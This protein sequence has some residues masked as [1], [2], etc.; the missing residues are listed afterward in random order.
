MKIVDSSKRAYVGLLILGALLLLGYNAYQS[1][2]VIYRPVLGR[3]DQVKLASRQWDQLE[4]MS[5]L[6]STENSSDIPVDHL[7]SKL[8]SDILKKEPIILQPKGISKAVKKNSNPNE[9]AETDL[10]ILT[11]VLQVSDAQGNVRS[12]AMIDGESRVEGSTVQ[13]FTIDRITKK[14]VTLTRK[15]ESWFLPAPEPS[16]SVN[17]EP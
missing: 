1:L 8:A 2:S 12:F 11:G 15:G 4:Q 7:S 14:G 10:P 6:S 16:F 17:Q 9:R 3:S 5:A 13:G